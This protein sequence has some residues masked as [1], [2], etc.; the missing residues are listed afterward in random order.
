MRVYTI[1]CL[2]LAGE[3]AGKS[4]ITLNSMQ[5]DYANNSTVLCVIC[6]VL[7]FLDEIQ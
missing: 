5:N 3:P 1:S 2:K 4:S 7:S 6:Y